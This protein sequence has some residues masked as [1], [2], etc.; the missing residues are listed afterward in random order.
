MSGV[1]AACAAARGGARTLLIERFAQFGGMA[2]IGGVCN[3][4]YGGPLEGQG[5][6]FD[7]QLRMMRKMGAIGEGNGWPAFQQL[8]K[9]T[10][11]QQI[12]YFNNLFDHNILPVVLQHQAVQAG[13][14]LLYHT[15]LTDVVMNGNAV[16]AV[17]IHNRSLL[18]AVRA[19]VVVDATGDGVLS[20]HAGAQIIPEGVADT[21]MPAGFMIF[22]SENGKL[23]VLPELYPEG[24]VPWRKIGYGD[25]ATD[26]Q[27]ELAAPYA[28]SDRF[29]VSKCGRG[30]IAIPGVG[31]SGHPLG[32]GS[33][34][35]KLRVYGFE[36]WT[37]EGLSAAEE[38]TR[39]LIPEIV[40]RAGLKLGS[41]V[42]IDSV[43]PMLGLRQGPRIL[44]EYILTVDDIKKQRVFKDCVAFG[45][46]GI[47]T[48]NHHV[49]HWI[50]P[51]QVPLRSLIADGVDNLFIVGRCASADFYAGSS[52]RVMTTC[53]LLGQ[54]AG[55]AAAISLRKS[56]PIREVNPAEIRKTLIAGADH[57]DVMCSRMDPEA[58][59]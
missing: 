10:K 20:R 21:R 24:E 38:F 11:G 35:V 27:K 19:R 58:L 28:G 43:P 16:E 33:S 40:R 36:T 9:N 23:E 32:N 26:E 29:W 4:A 13:V 46:A 54:A 39:S 53:C 6:V 57:P 49:D 15:E 41:G 31:I 30:K 37:G 50:A 3:W 17:I 56:V 12:R 55:T 18:Q 14:D 34:A 45:G 22:L 2:T 5:R 7:D 52:L 44:G 47:D 25:L 59:V 51:Y 8:P 48:V 1:G 42:K